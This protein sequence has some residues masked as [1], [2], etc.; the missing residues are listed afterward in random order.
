[1]SAIDD[2]LKQVPISQLASQVGAS[3]SDT[4]TAV[5]HA[6]TSLLGGMSANAADGGEA[7]LVAA[8]QSHAANPTTDIANVDTTDGAKIVQNVLGTNPQAAAAA[9]ATKTGAGNADLVAKVM[10]MLAPMVMTYVGSKLT[11]GSAV[12]SAASAGLGGLLSS[13]LLGKLF[14]GGSSSATAAAPA[15]SGGVSELLGGM[16]GNKVGAGNSAA[17]SGGLSGLLNSIF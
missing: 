2:I 4:Q 10:P 9:V 6:V 8:A 16:L 17:S 12:G 13:G 5:S 11:H 15:A 1:M 3:E 14:G 7:A